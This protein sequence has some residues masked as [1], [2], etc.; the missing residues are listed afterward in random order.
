[1]KLVLYDYISIL[2]KDM[3]DNINFELDLLLYNLSLN[4]LA[5][6]DQVKSHY[7]LILTFSIVRVTHMT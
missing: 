3:V 1:M 5:V 2:L 4:L 6:Y 7:V